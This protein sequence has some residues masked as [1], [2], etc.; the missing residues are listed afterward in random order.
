M[1]ASSDRILRA[2]ACVGLGGAG[3]FCDEVKTGRAA[4]DR[5]ESLR[6]DYALVVIDLELRDMSPRDI[7]AIAAMTV[8]GA[9][10]IRCGSQDPADEDGQ[11]AWI[12]KPVLAS[13]FARVVTA[14]RGWPQGVP[15]SA[16]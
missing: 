5:L 1:V 3:M 6:H 12:A 13:E 2:R 10:V 11:G 14:L 7:E 8:P 15:H 16:A 9:E 4:L